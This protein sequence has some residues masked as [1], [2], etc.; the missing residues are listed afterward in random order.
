MIV[1]ARF[2]GRHEYLPKDLRATS[3]AGCATWRGILSAELGPC[4]A[5]C[6]LCH[7]AWRGLT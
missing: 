7:V 5:Q 6:K 4:G 3:A 2:S 1:S